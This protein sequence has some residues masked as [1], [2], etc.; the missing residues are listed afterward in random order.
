MG[1]AQLLLLAWAVAAAAMALVFAGARRAGK[2]GYVDVA[3]AGLMAL[4]ALLVAACAGGTPLSR[5][6]VALLGGAWGL[7]LCLYL[8]RRVAREAED[9]RYLALRAR[10]GDAALPFF[11]FFQMQALVVALFALPFATVATRATDP[12]AWQVA[13]AAGVWILAVGGEALADFQL[14]RFRAD[15]RNHGHT[16]RSGLWAWSRHPN[17][18]F[19]WL[20]WSSY[21]L[22]ALGSPRWWLALSGPVLMLLFLYRLSGIPWTEAQ[23]LRSRGEDYRRYQREVSAFFPLPPRRT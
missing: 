14:A 2:I 7:R 3:W 16:C 1:T 22:L 23:A 21:L 12:Q 11:V 6:L 9:G 10:F 19:E 8:W 20:H 18:F 17:Y 5:A 15:P 4:S 13:A